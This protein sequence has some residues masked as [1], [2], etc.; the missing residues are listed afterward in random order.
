[1][2]TDA[3]VRAALPF[4]MHVELLHSTGRTVEVRASGAFF[5]VTAAL[6]AVAAPLDGALVVRPRG[7]ILEALGLT[8]FSDPHVR[9]DAVGARSITPEGGQPSYELTLDAHLR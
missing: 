7:L 9:I 4:G 8:L 3:D 6:D 1:V 5:G 2:T